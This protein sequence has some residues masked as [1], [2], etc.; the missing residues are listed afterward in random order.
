MRELFV[1]PYLVDR[2]RW[3]HILVDRQIIETLRACILYWDRVTVPMVWPGTMPWLEE[4]LAFLAEHGSV[5]FYRVKENKS[6]SLPDDVHL[7][8]SDFLCRAFDQQRN[9]SMLSILCPNGDSVALTAYVQALMG[10]PD[11]HYTFK[12]NVL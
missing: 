8:A 3:F 11:Q 6:L 2:E 5:S 12:K 7:F 1:A 9:G 4:V 10:Q